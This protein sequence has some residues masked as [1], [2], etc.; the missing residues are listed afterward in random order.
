MHTRAPPT[1]V[2]FALVQRLGYLGGDVIQSERQ[3]MAAGRPG[4]SSS[5]GVFGCMLHAGEAL[6][7]SPD[8]W[9]DVLTIEPSFSLGTRFRASRTPWHAAGTGARRVR[10]RV[11]TLPRAVSSSLSAEGRSRSSDRVLPTPTHTHGVFTN[12]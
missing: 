11:R 8:T 4:S 3:R 5:A 9:H 12:N 10:D 1:S 7:M 6:F 2:R